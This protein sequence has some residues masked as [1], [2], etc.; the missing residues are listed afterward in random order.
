MEYH[1]VKEIFLRKSL[2]IQITK[3]I[4]LVSTKIEKKCPFN[5]IK[6]L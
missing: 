5:I 2:F 3:M 1:N 6:I 4:K